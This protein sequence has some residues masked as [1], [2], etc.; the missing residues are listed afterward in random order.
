MNFPMDIMLVLE[1]VAVTLADAP[2]LKVTLEAL[3]LANDP[4][5]VDVDN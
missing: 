5:G 4:E 1:M 3:R 2:A